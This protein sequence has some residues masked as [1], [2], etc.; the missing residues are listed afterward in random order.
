MPNLCLGTAAR[1]TGTT[2]ANG[3]PRS[4]RFKGAPAVTGTNAFGLGPAWAALLQCHGRSSPAGAGTLLLQP[5]D[6][7]AEPLEAGGVRGAIASRHRLAPP[8]EAI[9]PP[10]P[11]RVIALC[12]THL[13]GLDRRGLSFRVNPITSMPRPPPPP[14]NCGTNA[15]P[16]RPA[17]TRHSSGDQPQLRD[18]ALQAAGEQTGRH[19]VRAGG[20]IA[21]HADARPPGHPPT[22]S[23]FEL[24]EGR[25]GDSEPIGRC[26]HQLSLS[27]LA[28]TCG[29]NGATRG[30]TL[31][32][33]Y[34]IGDR[35]M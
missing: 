15:F 29:F 23:R 35:L 26:W 11:A 27:W 17:R 33:N 9:V 30:R 14:V 28:P 3:H 24:S 22:S 8:P 18:R 25:S 34:W 13:S 10:R 31:R 19:R 5:D 1:S 21:I 32:V 16:L 2:S 4:P 6:P 12:G 7:Q 20:A